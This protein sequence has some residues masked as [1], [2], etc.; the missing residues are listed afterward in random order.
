[1]CLLD[2]Y[3]QAFI[4]YSPIEEGGDNEINLHYT[5]SCDLSELLGT[6]GVG[7][8]GSSSKVRC[9]DRN[10]CSLSCSHQAEEKM[11]KHLK[12]ATTPQCLKNM[13]STTHGGALP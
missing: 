2:L 5:L 1:M 10:G 6:T 9:L 12:R 4:G 13:R 7:G 3:T 8:T 11:R